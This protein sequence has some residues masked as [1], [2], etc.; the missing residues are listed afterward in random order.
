MVDQNVWLSMRHFLTNEY[1]NN[2]YMGQQQYSICNTNIKTNGF[3]E[4]LKSCTIFA[5]P[6]RRSQQTVEFIIDSYT[7]IKFNVIYLDELKE[8][9]LGDFEGKP[10]EQIRSNK[11]FFVDKKFIVTKTPPN[12]ESFL[13]FR[14]RVENI[15]DSMF[16]EF[17]SD[18]ILV[19]SHLQ[20]LRMIKFCVVNSYNYD[21]WHEINYAHGEIVKEDYGKE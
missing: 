2:I 7:D 8:R 4:C 16:K 18:N 1:R 12:G 9:G 5:S 13:D 17:K 14:K 6:L 21:V 19:V 10:K 11:E 3:L 20:T 15:I